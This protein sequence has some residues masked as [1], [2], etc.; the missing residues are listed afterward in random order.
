[1]REKNQFF[2]GAKIRI[3]CGLIASTC[4]SPFSNVCWDLKNDFRSDDFHSM[5]RLYF[6]HTYRVCIVCNCQNE[7]KE[8]IFSNASETKKCISSSVISKCTICIQFVI[9]QSVHAE[10]ANFPLGH[11]DTQLK[12][13]ITKK[14][15]RRALSF[16]YKNLHWKME[17]KLLNVLIFDVLRHM[18]DTIFLANPKILSMVM[19]AVCARVVHVV[20]MLHGL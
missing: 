15:E 20:R 19:R 9:P 2:I 12:R 16:G 18:S 1:M 3:Q 11:T 13:W 10:T 6:Q 7:K 8:T 5:K 4:I 14:S 17:W